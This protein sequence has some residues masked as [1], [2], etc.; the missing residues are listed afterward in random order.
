MMLTPV[1]TTEG[2]ELTEETPFPTKRA[3]CCFA[4]DLTPERS[5]VTIPLPQPADAGAKKYPARWRGIGEEQ[6]LLISAGLA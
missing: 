4:K 2:T 6:G 5:V 1:S 3:P